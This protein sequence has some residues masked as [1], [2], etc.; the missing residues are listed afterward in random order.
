MRANMFRTA[1]L[2][3]LLGVAVAACDGDSPTDTDPFQDIPSPEDLVGAWMTVDNENE[4]FFAFLPDGTYVQA[5]N[6]TPD[7]DGQPGIERG[8]YTWEQ[9]TSRF[10]STCPSVDTNGEWG[11]SHPNGAPCTGVPASMGVNAVAQNG[12][13]AFM[14]ADGDAFAMIRVE[15]EGD[16][17]VGGWTAEIDGNDVMLLFL[18]S[19]RY[20]HLEDGPSDDAGQTGFEIGSYSWSAADG[21]FATECPDTDANGEWGLSHPDPDAGCT[22]IASEM[23][24]TLTVDGDTAVVDF[25]GGETYTFARVTR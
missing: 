6:G 25:G 1:T 10:T 16:P 12:A 15:N 19:N 22:G 11:F 24:V 20:V 14:P 23:G 17:L 5:E 18:G 13:V 4:V 8:S 9:S 2:C 21:A 3:S 7:D